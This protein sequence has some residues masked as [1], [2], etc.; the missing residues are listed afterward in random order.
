MNLEKKEKEK[1][2]SGRG[3]R[4]WRRCPERGRRRK[5]CQIPC[6]LFKFPGFLSR[7]PGTMLL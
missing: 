5:N 2:K 4:R 7:S 1:K 3:E 6:I